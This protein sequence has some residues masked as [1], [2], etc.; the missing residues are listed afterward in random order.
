MGHMMRAGLASLRRGVLTNLCVPSLL[1][2][3][4]QRPADGGAGG[5]ISGEGLGGWDLQEV[6]CGAGRPKVKFQL[7]CDLK[8]ETV[9]VSASSSMKGR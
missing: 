1:S 4:G 2:E 3:G 6:Q 9:W 5:R 7:R 8:Q